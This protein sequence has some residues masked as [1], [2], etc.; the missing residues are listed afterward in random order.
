MNAA[1]SYYGGKQRLA[2]KIVHLLPAHTVFVEPFCGGAAVLFGKPR[3]RVRNQGHYREVLNDHDETIINFYRVLQDREQA[4]E[5][6]RRVRF[7]AYSAGDYAEAKRLTKDKTGAPVLRAWAWLVNVQQ[8]FG[9]DPHGGWARAVYSEN[10][11]AT[12]ALSR[13]ALGAVLA[14]LSEVSI[15]CLDALACIQTWD[16]PQTCFYCDPPYPGTDQ[17]DYRGYTL[18]DFAALCGL[19]DQC[20]GSFVLSCYDNPVL[21]RYPHW[22]RFAFAAYC[23]VNG[24]GRTGHDHTRKVT[25]EELGDNAR[26]ELILRVDRSHTVREELKPVLRQLWA[27]A[28]QQELFPASRAGDERR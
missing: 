22:E 2:S 5:L 10:R 8:S 11:A 1:F 27:P 28:V 13:R 15:E 16:S 6:V 4:K 19:L 25:A 20:Q 26:T 9:H 7:T 17:G 24:Q 18:E 3:P 14:R 23:S 12:W 21:A